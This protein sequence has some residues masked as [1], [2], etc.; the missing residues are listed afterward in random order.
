VHGH[1][2]AWDRAL[3]PGGRAA[4]AH[5]DARRPERSRQQLTGERLGPV[6]QPTALHEHGG[7]LSAEGVQ[8]LGHLAGDG[9][10]ADH[11]QPLRH[12]LDAGRIPVRP[13]ARLP[14]PG[15]VGNQRVAAGRHHDSVPGPQRPGA[16]VRR[17]HLGPQ[18][19]G[20]PSLTPDERRRQALDRA[21]HAVV[22]EVEYGLVAAGQYRGGADRA[23][24]LQP[25]HP[26]DLCR[27]LHR[28]QQRLARDAR[29]V[30]AFTARQAFLDEGRRQAPSHDALGDA[31][32]DRSRTYHDHVE[33][34]VLVRHQPF[35]PPVVAGHAAV[36]TWP[37]CDGGSCRSGS[38]QTDLRNW[39]SFAAP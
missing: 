1:R 29:E 16:A 3:D 10:S 9:S 37:V 39:L 25:G 18:R 4:E 12:L 7:L 13:R 6:E 31:H 21:D 19:P 22:V 36:V 28:P 26:A 20:Q 30:L 27:Q 5:V 17:R 33:D 34:V 15:G 38:C 35:H 8:R 32:P 23:A 11:D 14:Q 2:A 24:Q